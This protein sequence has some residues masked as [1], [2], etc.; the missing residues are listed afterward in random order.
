MKT[1]EASQ[2][3]RSIAFALDI[4]ETLK[5]RAHKTIDGVVYAPLY[6]VEDSPV[7][8]CK[9]FDFSGESVKK[10]LPEVAALCE[11]TRLEQTIQEAR[12]RISEIQSK[13]IIC[14]KANTQS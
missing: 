6:K 4:V 9:L 2:V 12:A 13:E 1:E 14:R 8:N 11:I 3:I 7:F 10:L 5:T